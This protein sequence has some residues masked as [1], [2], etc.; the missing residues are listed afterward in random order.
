M[1]YRELYEN[2]E[3]YDLQGTYDK[4]NN[5]Y[6]N[7]E[8]PKIPVEFAQLKGIGGVVKAR[9]TYTGPVKIRNGKQY[10][11]APRH[12]MA[13][14]TKLV[15][16]SMILQ[17]SSMFKRTPETIDG[18]LLHEM[19]HVYFYHIG[20]TAENHGQ[21][22]LSK[23]REISRLSGIRVPLKDS[24]ADDELANEM[25]LKA[26]GVILVQKADNSYM[27]ALISPKLA[28]AELETIKHKW[29]GRM[30]KVYT[31]MWLYTVA[32]PEWTKM[33]MR[34]PI[35]RKIDGSFYKMLDKEALANIFEKG[36]KL[37]EV[38]F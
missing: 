6:F 12:M 23:L 10:K 32:T 37:V 18:I 35:A 15:P 20:D 29:Q 14:Y 33:A 38:A 3:A 7:G 30:S 11:A 24:T 22:F 1:R 27:F 36:H 13:H 16:G 19:I 21:K 2:P 34:F 9:T 4:F 26:V 31:K 5:A 25:A 17:I 8:L 28:H